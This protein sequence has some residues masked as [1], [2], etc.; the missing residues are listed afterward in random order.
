MWYAWFKHCTISQGERKDTKK[1]T[2]E[3]VFK[4][5]KE[6]FPFLEGGG[7]RGN[8]LLRL[9]S[10]SLKQPDNPTESTKNS[11]YIWIQSAATLTINT[12]NGNEKNVIWV[13]YVLSNHEYKDFP[14]DIFQLPNLPEKTS[15]SSES[16]DSESESKE[17]SGPAACV[18]ESEPAAV[19]AAGGRFWL[20]FGCKT[21]PD[22]ADPASS[23]TPEV[24]RLNIF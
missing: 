21:V 5:K 19:R 7:Q 11:G 16:S 23:N 9:M 8:K 17:N 22:A 15:E 20:A 14:M 3:K 6:I 4:M 13:N 1:D 18:M 12:K 24:L 10:K 2:R